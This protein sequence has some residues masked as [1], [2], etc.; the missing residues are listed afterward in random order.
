MFDLKK[1]IG[2]CNRVGNSDD[3]HNSLRYLVQL[4]SDFYEIPKIVSID[5]RTVKFEPNIE[6]LVFDTKL[7]KLIWLNRRI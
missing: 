6:C 3:L 7:M 5:I 4:C 1:K 2:L